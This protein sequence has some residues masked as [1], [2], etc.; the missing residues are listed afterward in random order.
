[1]TD[2]KF[3]RRQNPAISDIRVQKKFDHARAWERK[4]ERTAA[5]EE[6]LLE[7]LPRDLARLAAEY[8]SGE[9]CK[10]EVLSQMGL[11]TDLYAGHLWHTRN[12]RIV[13][14]RQSPGDLGSWLDS[15][16]R[17]SG[18]IIKE[19]SLPREYVRS[20]RHNDP[21]HVSDDLS[22]RSL[23]CVQMWERIKDKEI[24]RRQLVGSEGVSVLPLHADN[25]VNDVPV[26]LERPLPLDW[27]PSEPW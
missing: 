23:A 26:P 25:L 18:L 24:A 12:E 11:F 8:D 2:Q 5:V 9:R 10:E 1:M 13:G 15:K 6:E 7:H 4:K 14:I 22:C 16:S 3:W 27:K 17:F 19:L 20:M 21:E